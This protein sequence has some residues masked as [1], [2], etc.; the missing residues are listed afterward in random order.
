MMTL[1]KIF[2]LYSEAFSRYGELYAQA[3]CDKIYIKK[4]RELLK[5]INDNKT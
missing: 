2:R 3:Y 5:H 4:K 1:K